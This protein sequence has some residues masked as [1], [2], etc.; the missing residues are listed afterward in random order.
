MTQS[1]IDIWAFTHLDQNFC[2]PYMEGVAV[3]KWHGSWL[4]NHGSFV[5]SGVQVGTPELL[6][7][8]CLILRS[9]GREEAAFTYAS[10]QIANR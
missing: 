7:I 2:I 5:S 4:I 6:P 10:S 1:N 9:G 3:R 8:S